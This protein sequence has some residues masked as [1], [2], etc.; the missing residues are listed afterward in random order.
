MQETSR[1]T[2]GRVC[3]L[4]IASDRPT[5]RGRGR[6]IVL[7]ER[8][9]PNNVLI[10]PPK[11]K[12]NDH[13]SRGRVVFPSSLVCRYLPCISLKSGTAQP[14]TRPTSSK[15]FLRYPSSTI[16]NDSPGQQTQRTQ[17][18]RASNHVCSQIAPSRARDGAGQAGAGG[19]RRGR[20]SDGHDGRVL[21]RGPAEER[22]RQEH[23][24]DERVGGADRLVGGGSW[25]MSI[26]YESA[27]IPKTTDRGEGVEERWRT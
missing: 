6:G 8:R 27:G 2:R 25:G 11:I 15:T 18:G 21:G 24:A 22:A 10:T 14:R 7:V 16:A 20:V 3:E 23:T 5:G 1:C 9:S 17:A 19:G 12:L 13:S 4:L 26:F